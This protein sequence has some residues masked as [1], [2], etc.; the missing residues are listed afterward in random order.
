MWLCLAVLVLASCADDSDG[1]DSASSSEGPT[2]TPRQSPSGAAQGASFTVDGR[3]LLLDCTGEGAPTMVLEVGE[4]AP[5]QA[6][7]GIGDAYRSQVRVCSYERASTDR[8]IVSD[9]HGLLEAAH[10]PGPYLLVGHSAG[11]LLVQA[12]AAA[13]PDETAGVVAINP[14]PAWQAWSTLA[15]NEMTSRE[16]KDE[17]AYYG[18]ANGESLDYRDISR[19]IAESPAPRT[20]PLHVLI[21]TA[22]QCDSPKDICARTYPAYEQISRAVARR[23]GEGRFSEV[24]APH[25]IPVADVQPAIDDVISR[26][27]Q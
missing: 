22:A 20:I 1:K 15:F 13:Y 10:V 21:S 8:N 4:G 23:W 7:S 27:R 16:R 24:E 26:A 12:Y 2:G 6:L 25:E 9:L 14:V 17:A 18:G 5:R 11:G 3:E 19:L